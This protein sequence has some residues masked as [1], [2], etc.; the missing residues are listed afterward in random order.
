MRERL[1][2]CWAAGLADPQP[3]NTS[4]Q[5][6]VFTP[7]PETVCL[8]GWQTGVRGWTVLNSSPISFVLSVRVDGPLSNGQLGK[9]IKK[10][11]RNTEVWKSCNAKD[12]ASTPTLILC[13]PLTLP[14][15]IKVTTSSLFPVAIPRAIKLPGELTTTATSGKNIGSATQR[16]KE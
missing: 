12:S 14:E 15:K 8:T 3:F 9:A 5:S 4:Y 10:N 13:P 1:L 11:L 6:P 7:A 2:A 16:E